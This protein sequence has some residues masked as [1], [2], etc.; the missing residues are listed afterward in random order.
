MQQEKH[1]NLRYHNQAKG[2][3]EKD[4]VHAVHPT[5]ENKIGSNRG[6]KV[7][8]RTSTKYVLWTTSGQYFE[9]H[10]IDILESTFQ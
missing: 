2:Q 8:C 9:H 10:I 1:P 3:A 4:H 5:K 7:T 6:A